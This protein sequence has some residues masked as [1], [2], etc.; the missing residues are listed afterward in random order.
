MV[1]YPICRQQALAIVQQLVLS[2]GGDD[3]MG[4]LLGMMH[5]APVLAVEFKTYILK[6]ISF[7]KFV[8]LLQHCLHCLLTLII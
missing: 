2:T 6:V 8:N 3:D 4:T 7:L 1:P 5:S